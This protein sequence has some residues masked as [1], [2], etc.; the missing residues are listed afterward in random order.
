MD[1]DGV[2]EGS[3]DDVDLRQEYEIE[4]PIEFGSES[5]DCFSV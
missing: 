3:E 1:S 2:L 5:D 4:A